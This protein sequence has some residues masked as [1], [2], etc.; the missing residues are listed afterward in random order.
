MDVSS[1]P[2]YII[3]RDHKFHILFV[4]L[5]KNLDKILALPKSLTFALRFIQVNY[6]Q[7]YNC[8]KLKLRIN[9]AKKNSKVN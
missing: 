2:L 9:T 5:A 4:K 3:G 8:L 6:F 1:Q 7:F